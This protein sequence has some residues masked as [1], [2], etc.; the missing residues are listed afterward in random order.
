[1][2]LILHLS[3]K[4]IC[5]T[6][7]R[8]LTQSSRPC[9]ICCSTEKL[10]GGKA[11]RKKTGNGRSITKK[12]SPWGLS[13]EVVIWSTILEDNLTIAS[14]KN[15]YKALKMQ[16]LWLSNSTCRKIYPRGKSWISMRIYLLK[17][18]FHG[19]L[20]ETQGRQQYIHL[21]W[22]IKSGRCLYWP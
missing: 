17:K 13:G 14:K 2:V 12:D 10:P 7:R 3:V 5:S 8:P 16:V 15:V 22:I 6:F 11:R 20:G 18:S 19:T 9:S 4:H 21:H 1:M